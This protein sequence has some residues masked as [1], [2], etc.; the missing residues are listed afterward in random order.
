[1]SGEAAE[2]IV[3]DSAD[4]G[5]SDLLSTAYSVDGPDANRALYAQWA[6]TYDADF[7]AASG[8]VYH[9]HVVDLLLRTRPSLGLDDAVLDVGCGTGVV[10]EALRARTPAAID[11]IDISPEMLE[12][13][14][15]KRLD[16]DAVYRD[17]IVADLTGPIDVASDRYTALIST[18]TFTHGHVGPDALGELV[19]VCAP[20]ASCAI[21]INASHFVEHGFDTALKRLEDDG[22]LTT[23]DLA[24]VP[25]YTAAP[26]D[27]DSVA[28]VALLTIT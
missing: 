15:A 5:V 24:S 6:A 16:G 14:G 10:G 4:D 2:G 8:Y 11:G 22:V 12:R 3:E 25:I 27:H 26:G 21:G 23:V 9:E 18:G 17:L 7:V 1:M 19:R 13:A 20:G 28:N